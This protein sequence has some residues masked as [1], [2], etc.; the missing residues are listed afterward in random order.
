MTPRHLL[1]AVASLLTAGLAAQTASPPPSAADTSA[2]EPPIV[3]SPFEVTSARDSGY[4]A[5]ET[6]AGT[7]IR[8]QLRDVGSAISVITKDFLNDIGATDN[9]T[10][11]QFT[12]N[13]EVA[14]TRG[15]YAGLGNGTSVDETS[16]LRA[17][18]GAQRVRGLAPADNTRDFFV[19]DIPW[20]S[21]NTDRIDI[22]R[23]PN[24]ILFGL[25]SPAGIVNASI[26]GAEFRNVGSAEV[27][28]GSYGSER[29]TL[30]VNRV[31]FD[32]VLAVRVT[33]LWDHEK[34]R[35]EPAFENDERVSVGVR[36]DPRLFDRRDFATSLKVKFEH[37][38]IEANRPRIVP[39]AD[40]ITPWFRP[41]NNTSLTG[42]MGKLAVNNGYEVGANPAGLNPW[43]A[44]PVDQQQPIWLI[45]GVTNQLYQIY[46]GYVNTGARNNDGSNRGAGNGLI[47]Q[48]FSGPF[49]RLGSLDAFAT[50]ARIPGFQYGQYRQ[51][52]LRDPSVFNFYD[53]LIDGDTK[54][55]FEKWDAYNLDFS[56]TGFD[57]RIGLQLTYDRQKYKRGG[58]ALISNPTLTIDILRNFQDLSPN[59]NFGR[60]YV[61]AGPGTGNS[62]ESDRTY[63]RGSLFTELRARDLLDNSFLVKLLGK[64][65]LNGVFSDETY[66]TENRQW[67]MYAHGRDWA[68]YWNQTNGASSSFQDRPPV[69]AIY[70]GS[71][72][73]NASSASGAGLP[74]IGTPVTLQNG[75]IYHFA[76]TWR[77]LPGVNFTD[78]WT[79][80]A[81]LSAIFD[82]AN[83]PAG[84]FTQVSN[85]ANYVGWNSN[86][87]A[88]LL[89]YDDGADLSLTTLAQKSRRETRSF[90]GSWQ[91]FLWNDA[92]V[93]TLGW[94]YDEVRGKA[95][96][97][98]P[99]TLNRSVLNLQPDAYRLPDAYPANQIFK[100]HSTAGGVVVHLNRLFKKDPLPLNASLSYN[101]SS[102]F[103]VTD[104]RRDVYGSP[105]TNPTGSTRDYGVLLA[106]RDGKFSVRAVRYE[107]ALKN[108]NA[109]LSLNGLASTV[110]DG[111]RWRNVFLYKMS[112]YT[113]DTREQTNDTPGQ[114]FFWT[115]AYINSAGRPV[116]DLN[117][118]PTPPAGAILETTEQAFARRDAAIRAWNSI[119]LK[120]AS[121]GFFPAWNFTPT[122]ASALTDRATYERTLG[123]NTE[124]TGGR[125]V[126]VQ[127]NAAL[128]PAVSSLASYTGSVTAPPGLAVTSDAESEGYE[129]EFTANP[130]PNWRIAFNAS[131]T[132]A[133]RVNVGGA[134]LDELVTFL[135]EQMAGVAGDLRRFNGS[136]VASNEVRQSWI[137]WRGQYTLLKLQENA[138]A[139]E[140]RKW[141]YNIVTNYSFRNE[142]LKGVGIGGSYRWQDRV[143]IGYPVLPGSGTQANFDLDRP[144]YGPSEDA[145]D[146]WAS[147]ERRLSPRINWKV[148]LNIRNAFAEDGLIPIS[149]QPD[150]QTWA[151]VRVKPNQ[152]W[153][154]TNTFSF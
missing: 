16:S 154:V 33:G 81:S 136:Y 89:R 148:Q 76:S 138:A 68:G 112:G 47:G 23:G 4:Q 96:T 69:A 67:R 27:R 20:D 111:L 105:I 86:F 97:A 77:N 140:I 128:V 115:P 66:D 88:N 120:L 54:H 139:A 62:Y 100:D 91:G 102:N 26:R 125:T 5:T 65:R 95:V 87:P 72:L 135:D 118:V 31:L 79:V 61:L 129:L 134:T 92:I 84:G 53:V 99:V 144:Y 94:R 119:Q 42:G 101:K 44:Q 78:P 93:P 25:G 18:G 48:R 28:L 24:S 34:F 126:L 63:A 82:A 133:T 127:N 151:S 98:A 15:T 37:G 9:S 56:Q 103:Q 45:D 141:R 64:H 32:Q 12:P 114:R 73:A 147:Y 123:P 146:L 29:G 51:E 39:P 57:D 116:A 110:A 19:T 137:N 142:R 130:L 1:T 38:E 143:I 41:V 7:R 90:A 10:L 117:G 108:T 122:T 85:P 3:L 153:F 131:M 104:T 46:G 109:G 40:S 58:E 113:W 152:E 145:I 124:V 22:Q 70:L 11:L 107:T 150:G 21:Y 49:Y 83:P 35:Q 60:A 59:P 2:A 74:G 13:A 8:T 50:N 55:E 75:S 30:D 43:L 52:Q 80:P 17:P 14:G 106:T 71:S 121:T 132:E 149:V 36:F 6:L